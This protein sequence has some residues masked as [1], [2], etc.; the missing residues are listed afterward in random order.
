MRQ[1]IANCSVCGSDAKQHARGMCG[2]CYHRVRRSMPDVKA[3]HREYDLKRNQCDERKARKL[4]LERER[5]QRPEVRAKKLETVSLYR[6]RMRP[7]IRQYM[8]EYSTRPHVRARHNLHTRMRR[9]MGGSESRIHLAEPTKAALYARDGGLC[10]WCGEPLP[11]PPALFDGS[12]VHVDH[13]V[14]LANGGK[15]HMGNW[16]LLHAVC[17]SSK[18]TKPMAAAPIMAGG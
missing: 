17:N 1:D 12:L 16:Q 11:L 14:A 9:R 13:M 8:R 6:E 5:Y 7:Q 4:R 3:K 2:P 18:Q 10:G 15:H